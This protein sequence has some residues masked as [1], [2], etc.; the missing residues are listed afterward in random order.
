M[1]A[2]FLYSDSSTRDLEFPSMQ[3]V[4]DKCLNIEPIL[5]YFE[6]RL[7]PEGERSVTV[8]NELSRWQYWCL[9]QTRS[10]QGN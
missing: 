8:C 9:R 6:G 7:S 3:P 1:K 2:I 4:N 5:C 10:F